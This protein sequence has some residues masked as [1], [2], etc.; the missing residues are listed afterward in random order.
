MSFSGPSDVA[1]PMLPSVVAVRHEHP[2]EITA[3]KQTAK[4]FKLRII[5]PFLPK[6]I[7]HKNALPELCPD[8]TLALNEP[9]YL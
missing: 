6:W 3:T 9:Q 1:A 8:D 5:L 4:N 7:V 2:V